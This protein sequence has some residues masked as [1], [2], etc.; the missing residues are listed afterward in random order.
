MMCNS[1]DYDNEKEVPSELLY[2]GFKKKNKKKQFNKTSCYL[3][4]IFKRLGA[5]NK[6]NKLILI[7]IA[8]TQLNEKDISGLF[9]IFITNINF[10][11]FAEVF[12]KSIIKTLLIA[13]CHN[14]DL[15]KILLSNNYNNYNIN[16]RY[17]NYSHIC[18]TDLYFLESLINKKKRKKLIHIKILLIKKGALKKRRHDFFFNKY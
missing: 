8:T 5:N 16:K 18:C 4:E 14:I 7:N 17:V 6:Y 10:D 9:K 3:H 2:K 13:G 11:T 15:Y 12:Q 1:I